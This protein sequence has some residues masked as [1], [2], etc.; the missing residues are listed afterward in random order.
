MGVKAASAVFWRLIMIVESKIL[1][2]ISETM[3]CDKCPYPCDARENSS[4]A[5]C[6]LRWSK[7]LSMIETDCDWQEVR[8]RVAERS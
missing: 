6:V 8:F 2:A 3:T 4:Q 5:N 1:K 7:I